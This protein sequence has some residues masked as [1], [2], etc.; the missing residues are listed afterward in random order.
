MATVD[1]DASTAA[2]SVLRQ[3]GNAMDAAVAGAAALGVT[4]PYSAGLA[5]A[6]SSSTTTPASGR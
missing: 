3:G 5:G 6:A 4:E 2:L 1:L